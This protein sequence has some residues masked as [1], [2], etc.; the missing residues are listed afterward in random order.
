MIRIDIS[1]S[2]RASSS[3]AL[4]SRGSAGKARPAKWADTLSTEID[5]ASAAGDLAKL[6]RGA[7]ARRSRVA[8]AFPDD[9]LD[10]PLPR[11][12]RI[13]RDAPF[14][15]WPR[16]GD[17]SSLFERAQSILER[18][19]KMRPLAETHALLSSIDG[20][21]I[22]QGSVARDGA[23]DGVATAVDERGARRLARPIRASGCPR[24][25]RDLYSEGVR[26]RASSRPR[27]SSKRAIELFAKD[28]PKP[29]EPSWGKRRSVRVARAGLRE[30]AATR[31]KRRT[32][33]KTALEHRAGLRF[34]QKPRRGAEVGGA[35]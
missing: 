22:A 23:R 24:P 25:G 1:S 32:Q 4:R 15:S 6:A 12:T 16:G 10:S 8:T 29:G 34:A 19:A 18:S 27:N 35:T 31:P 28:A 20:Q 26:R 11:V 9:G 14:C 13:Y 33:Y 5:K 17:A 7:R 2:S 21:L 30:T 3:P